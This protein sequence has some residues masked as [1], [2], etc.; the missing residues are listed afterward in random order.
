MQSLRM[1]SVIGEA[2]NFGARRIELIARVAW[3]PVLLLLIVDMAAT[4]AELSVIAGRAITFADVASMMQAEQY[5]RQF[6][7]RGWAA[8][9]PKMLTIAVVHISLSIVLTASF[10]TPLIRYAGLGERPGPGLFRLPF[11]AD[12]LRFIATGAASLLIVLVLAVLPAAGAGYFVMQAIV[13]AMTKTMATFPDPESLHT[14]EIVA[15]GKSIIESGSAWLFDLALPLAAAAPFALLVWIVG[16]LHFH[17]RNRPNAHEG[18]NLVLRALVVFVIAAA[19]TGGAYL[20]LRGAAM[21]SLSGNAQGATATDLTGTPVNAILIFITLGV[22]LFAYA[23]LRLFAWPGVAVCRK[24]MAL[25]GALAVTRG[26]NLFRLAAILFVLA[27]FLITALL[28]INQLL[29]PAILSTLNTLFRA[30]EVS[31]RLVNSGA[32]AEWVLPLFVWIWNFAKIAVNFLWAFFSY[33]A[34]A[35]LYGRLYRESAE[36]G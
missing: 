11:G 24:S 26:W 33:G 30:T 32:K 8:S 34:L 27:G 17:P 28:V 10:L 16:V 14:I 25:G 31:T 22:F 29:L 21:Q 23:N 20:M 4:F 6:A 2:L 9:P 13:E 3:L 18:G 1:F 19:L 5:A 12:Q 35:G 15:S 36:A 7:E